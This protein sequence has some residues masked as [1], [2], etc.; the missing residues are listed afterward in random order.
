MKDSPLVLLGGA[1]LPQTLAATI[2][3]VVLPRDV[4][5]S[6]VPDIPSRPGFVLDKKSGLRKLFPPAAHF[7]GQG[8]AKGCGPRDECVKALKI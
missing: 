6:A 2:N 1:P 5:P 7:L 3:A 8:H 4:R